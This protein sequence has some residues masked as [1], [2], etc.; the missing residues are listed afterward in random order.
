MLKAVQLSS[1]MKVSCGGGNYDIMYSIYS[2]HLTF[3]KQ[4]STCQT[5]T[6]QKRPLQI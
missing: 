6:L 1:E 2:V 3:K 4:Y 5:S